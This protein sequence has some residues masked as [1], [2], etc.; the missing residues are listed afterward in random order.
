MSSALEKA[1]SKLLAAYGVKAVWEMHL[2]ATA[3]SGRG[4]PELA[5]SLVGVAEA[6]ER[7]LMQSP[8]N[9]LPTTKHRR[10]AN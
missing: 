7:L 4:K 2:A 10:A 1:A 6:A 5:A 8:E 9:A 3:A